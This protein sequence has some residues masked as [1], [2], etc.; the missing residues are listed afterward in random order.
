MI[1][2]A[3]L[4]LFAVDEESPFHAA[5]RAWLT[6]RL[7]GPA[8]TGLPWPSLIAFVRIST[9]P[10]ASKR[11]LDPE[12][13]WQHVEDWLA[14]GSAWIPQP[15]DRHAEILGRLIRTYR[16]RGNA[17]PDAALAALALEHGLAVASA[18]SD[19]ARFDEVRWVNP[20]APRARR[21]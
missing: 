15:T 12:A 9:H 13:A 19:F 5:A 10:R 8:R 18:D 17:I 6:A 3:N 21:S 2:D 20:L 1:V 14:A 11:P 4:L 7:N 16:L